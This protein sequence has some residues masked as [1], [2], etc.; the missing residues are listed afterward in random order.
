MMMPLPAKQ[1]TVMMPQP[2]KQAKVMM[3]M[4]QHPQ[5]VCRSQ[6]LIADPPLGLPVPPG[7]SSICQGQ[8]SWLW[9]MHGV[10][11]TLGAVS[12]MPWGCVRG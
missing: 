3:S 11:L 8:S 2:V 9:G 7:N 6:H 10:W 12:M 4:G 5:S 1:A